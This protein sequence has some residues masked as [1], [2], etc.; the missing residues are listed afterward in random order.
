MEYAFVKY[1][2]KIYRT[3]KLPFETRTQVMDRLWFQI[4]G[5]GSDPYKWMYEKYYFV[6]FAAVEIVAF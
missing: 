1:N 5:D 6:S 3:K 4:K 2:G